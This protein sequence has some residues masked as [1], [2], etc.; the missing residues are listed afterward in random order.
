[1]PTS[2]KCGRRKKLR[3]K[4]RPVSRKNWS[5]LAWNWRRRIAH[6]I[7]R[8]CPSCNTARFLSWKSALLSL[9]M[10]SSQRRACC[11]TRSPK[12]KSLKWFPSGPASRYRRCWKAKKT[13]C[14]A[15]KSRWASAWWV[16]AKRSAPCPMPSVVRVPVFQIR[17]VPMVHFYFLDQPAS[18]K[19]SCAKHWPSSCS[20]LK[21]P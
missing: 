15:W 20:I 16:N 18:A 19:P 2:K 6:K 12:R 11:V 14:C 1:M 17:I 21:K 7:W 4:A 10:R 5:V 8:V 13:S 9:P 3:C